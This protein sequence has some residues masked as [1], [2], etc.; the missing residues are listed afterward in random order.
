[1][2]EARARR[3][4]ILDL[5]A[6]GMIEVERLSRTLGVSPS[7]IRRDL[8]R[9]SADGCILRTYGGAAPARPRSEDS[10]IE[11]TAINQAEKRAIARRAA[12]LV[13]AGDTVILDAGTTVGAL[14]QALAGRSALRV[15]TN[16]LTSI[17]ALSAS[18]GIELIVLG[19]RLRHI[20]LG[21]IGPVAE[22]ALARMTAASA[23]LGA[24]GVVA[25]RG[26]C[27]A[28]D[29]QAALKDM[30]IAQAAE[31]YV[32]ADADKLGHTASTAWTPLLRPWTLITDRR[33]TA[34]QLE[35]FRQMDG[36]TVMIAD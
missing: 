27:E 8:A 30:M 21:M 15:I 19:G 4:R 2:K 22:R 32:L 14:A 25:G 6:A 23:F 16:G 34:P 13:G 26:I 33:A 5:T 11:R 36:V 31:I 7:T 28:S 3:Q 24:D 1:M 29:E 18:P 10:L 35:A 20:S 17:M 12:S 9:L